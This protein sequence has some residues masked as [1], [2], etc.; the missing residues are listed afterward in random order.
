MQRERERVQSF[1]RPFRERAGPLALLPTHFR[2]RLAL[3]YL[4]FL[5][6]GL[7][8]IFCSILG[9]T[10]P[11]IHP[12]SPKAVA[13]NMAISN[14]IHESLPYIDTEPTASERA[15]A[16]NLI[17]LESNMA[18][19]DAAH[20]SVPPLAPQNFTPA[21]ELEFKR[22]A[23]KQPL[24]AIQ[25]SRYEAVE[26]PRTSPH[27]DEK[28]PQ[29]LEQWKEALKRAYISQS[30]LTQR[31][32]NLALLEK[33]GKNGWLVGNSQLEDVLRALEMELAERKTE[34][35]GVVVERKG[36]Q[37]NVGGEVKGL[38]ETWKRGVGRIL[39]TEVAAERVRREILERRR[40]FAGQF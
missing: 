35:D 13:D 5:H 4:T 12:L 11:L 6:A 24:S 14:A 17:D 2:A 10:S 26:P 37:E 18:T 16:Q 8:A 3:S 36:A 23:S 34:I 27:S 28:D 15:A 19:P 30:Y 38:E 21:M 7:I 39:E 9:P 20:L 22:L 29:S 31:Q 25:L 33:Y 1:R 32:T 40:H